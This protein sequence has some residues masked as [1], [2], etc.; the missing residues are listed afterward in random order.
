IPGCNMAFYK[1]ALEEVGG[2]DPMFQRA[3]DDV[4]ICWR[5]QQSGCRI[6]FSPA[7]F[8]WHFRRSTVRDYLKQQQGYG[9]AEALLVQKHPEYFNAF[10]G[11]IWQGRIYSMAKTGLR[12]GPRIIYHG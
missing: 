12:V 11:S 2:F 9:E 6:G 4:D 8:V 1:W 5:L 7:A 10:G 3:G